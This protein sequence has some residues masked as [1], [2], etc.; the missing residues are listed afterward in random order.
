MVHNNV[1]IDRM[2]LPE[3]YNYVGVYLTWA[4]QLR[5]EYCLNRQWGAQTGKNVVRSDE[6]VVALS[7][8]ELPEDIPLTFQGGEP[9]LHPEFYEIVA[10]VP[11]STNID[12]LTNG[13]F[14]VHEF[15]SHI[16]PERMK[17][18]SKYA[19]I[20]FSYHP[21]YTNIHGLLTT[22]TL[23]QQRGYSVGVWAVNHPQDRHKLSVF[24]EL[25]HSA[26][27]DFRT[28]DYLGYYNGRLCGKYKYKGAFN[29]KDK[30]VRC[31]IREVIVGPMLDIY[32]CT[33]DLYANRT[34]IGSLLDSDYTIDDIYRLCTHF[35]TGCAFCDMK[36]KFDRFQQTG[37]C[38][39]DVSQMKEMR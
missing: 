19:S 38:S 30:T 5:C 16:S 3:T 26:R 7:R 32:R 11:K 29:G 12:L 39:V 15:M 20:R 33:G 36:I 17:R 25:C 34:P 9:T 31:R 22:M 21:G 35:G 14:N 4:C 1:H 13:M 6:W 2:K 24:R 8:L 28:K 27:L 10:G 37:H 18:K 23:M